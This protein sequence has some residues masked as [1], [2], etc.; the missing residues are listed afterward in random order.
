MSPFVARATD[1][2]VISD[3]MIHDIDIV[4][5]LIDAEISHISAAG[6]AC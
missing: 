2:D 4:L 5:S 1:V 6:T 3:L